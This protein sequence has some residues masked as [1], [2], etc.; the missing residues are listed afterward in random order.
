MFYNSRFKDLENE[1]DRKPS[2][3]RVSTL[4]HDIMLHKIRITRL[5]ERL[6]MLLDYLKV[7]IKD[8]PAKT[9]ILPRHL[10]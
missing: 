9:E 2:S 7:Q 6:S 3:A 5:E 10:N 4:E 8:T 1:I